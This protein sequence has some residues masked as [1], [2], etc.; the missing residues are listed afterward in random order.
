MA[1]LYNMMVLYILLIIFK[2]NKEVRN[3]NKLLNKIS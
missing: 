3:T 1:P 2:N